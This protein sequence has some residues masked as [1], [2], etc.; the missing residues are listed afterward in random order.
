MALIDDGLG[1]RKLIDYKK[2][3]IVQGDQMKIEEILLNY[4][5]GTIDI[6]EASEEIKKAVVEALPK[7]IDIDAMKHGRVVSNTWG[8]EGY[9]QALS[10]IIKAV[11][12]L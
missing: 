7:K 6:D 3:P 1:N 5:D 2:Y 11:E 9:N 12:N 10:D 4:K 8:E